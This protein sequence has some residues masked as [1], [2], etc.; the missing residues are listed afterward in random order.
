MKTESPEFEILS[1]SP[2]E[3]HALGQKIGKA[4]STGMVITLTGDLGSGKTAF[5]QGLSRHI[6]YKNRQ[7]Q[8]Q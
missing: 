6:N 4:L 1:R 2:A 7:P 8:L 3:T 5:V